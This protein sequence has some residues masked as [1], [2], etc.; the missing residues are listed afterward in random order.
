MVDDVARAICEAAGRPRNGEGD[1]CIICKELP[2]GSRECICWET[3]RIEARDA[4]IA[5]HKWYKKERRWPSFV[6]DLR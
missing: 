5:A 4:I 1:I 6:K 3:F 2:D